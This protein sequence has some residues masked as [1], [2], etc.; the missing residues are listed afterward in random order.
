[1][2]RP[3]IEDEIRRRIASLP[4][5]HQERVLDFVRSLEPTGEGGASG[6]DLVRF[7]GTWPGEQLEEMTRIIDADCEQVDPDA[8]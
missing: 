1:M 2:I 8:W 3:G 6:R 5:A 7:A 4:P